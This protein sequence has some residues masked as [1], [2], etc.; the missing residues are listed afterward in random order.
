MKT[1]RT[2]SFAQFSAIP[3]I[4]WGQQAS[5]SRA[6]SVSVSYFSRKEN[7]NITQYKNTTLITKLINGLHILCL[8]DRASS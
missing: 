4:P 6:A 3:R 2:V 1:S 5:G 7:K 8:L